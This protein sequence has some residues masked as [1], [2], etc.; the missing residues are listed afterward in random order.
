LAFWCSARR[1]QYLP[2][3]ACHSPDATEHRRLLAVYLP[4]S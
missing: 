2:F 1:M 3:R 4:N